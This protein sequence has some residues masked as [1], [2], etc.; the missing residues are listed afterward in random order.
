MSKRAR[1]AV[2]RDEAEKDADENTWQ[3]LHANEP[4]PP[5]FEAQRTEAKQNMSECVRCCSSGY[6]WTVQF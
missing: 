1:A 2:D 5:P 6:S 4:A 3:E